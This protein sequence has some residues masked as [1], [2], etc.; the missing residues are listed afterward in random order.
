MHD[1]CTQR[2]Q[3]FEQ[4][5]RGTHFAGESDGWVDV[6]NIP[7]GDVS[8]GQRWE[9]GGVGTPGGG[10]FG[11]GGC[12]Y[13]AQVCTHVHVEVGRV[14]SWFLLGRAVTLS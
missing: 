3:S 5:E 8:E 12:G 1:D 13:F 11:E 2:K 4:E 14:P 6:M 9:E 7:V 10:A